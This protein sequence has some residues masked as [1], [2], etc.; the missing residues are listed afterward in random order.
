[1]IFNK[2]NRFYPKTT[3]LG[4][5]NKPKVRPKTVY[6]SPMTGL[7]SPYIGKKAPRRSIPQ[8]ARCFINKIVN[9]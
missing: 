6:H 1:M 2:N 3:T 5:V 4:G 7:G 9:C 8:G